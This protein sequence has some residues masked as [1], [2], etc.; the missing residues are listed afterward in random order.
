MHSEILSDNQKEL[1]P[2]M[3]QFR[4]EYYLVGGAVAGTGVWGIPKHL[5]Q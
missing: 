3:A 1:L 2:L 4:R 5:S